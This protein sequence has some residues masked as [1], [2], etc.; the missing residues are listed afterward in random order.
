MSQALK[1]V[2]SGARLG[3]KEAVELIHLP[4]EEAP[5]LLAAAHRVRLAFKGHTVSLCAIVNAKSGRCGEDCAFCAQS[6]HYRTQA[7]AYPLLSAEEIVARAREAA[8]QGARAFGIVTSGSRI[9]REEEWAEIL[10]AVRTIA[11]EGLLEPHASLGMLTEEQAQELKAAGLTTYHHNLETAPSFFPHICT[12]HPLEEDLATVRAAKAA[13][14]TVCCGGI[15]GL[16]ETPAQRVELAL[17]LRELDV[18][19]VP[20]NFLNPIPGTPLE[21]RPLLAPWEALKAIAVFRLL[22][23]DKDIRL[24]GGKEKTLRQLLPLGLLAGANGLMTGNYLTTTGREPALDRE[25]V[26]DLG[27]TLVS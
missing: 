17:T 14:L 13:G 3:E 4:P 11:A 22:L 10:Q 19:S 12:T 7:A 25:L 21:N 23:P 15:L 5:D 24:C 2:L 6:S 8:A 9:R 20:L 26:T 1:T 27:L 16:G 18:D